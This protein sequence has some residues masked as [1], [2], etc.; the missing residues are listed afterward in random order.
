MMPLAHICPSCV[1]AFLAAVVAG[2][3]FMPS[4]VYGLWLRCR[5][6]CSRFLRRRGQVEG[7]EDIVA[8]VDGRIPGEN[9]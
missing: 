3:V 1:G 8:D 7:I 6:T 4:A 5:N 9:P 2:V